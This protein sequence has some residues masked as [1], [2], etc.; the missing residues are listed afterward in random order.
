MRETFQL[1][2][3]VVG[4]I[5]IVTGILLSLG[6]VPRFLHPPEWAGWPGTSL[7]PFLPV[8]ESGQKVIDVQKQWIEDISR[9]AWRRAALDLCLQGIVPILL[10]LYL[11]RSGDFF[12]RLAYPA[13]DL[14]APGSEDRPARS[15][16]ESP[17]GTPPPF[18]SPPEKPTDRKYAPP[19]LY[20]A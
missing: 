17:P 5:L 12:V 1:C 11:L 2:S 15:P 9:T 3:K 10:G 7:S 13:G 16:P 18:P 4:L 6:Q 14:T 19:G 20:D 8:S